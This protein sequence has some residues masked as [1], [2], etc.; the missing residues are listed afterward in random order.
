MSAVTFTCPHCGEPGISVTA[1]LMSS[2]A[3]WWGRSAT[4]R[5]CRQRSRISGAAVNVQFGIFVAALASIPWLL[6]GDARIAVGYLVA[7]A[8]LTVGLFAP[9]KKDLTS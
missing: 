7:A 1:K 9:M 3:L 6:D 2:A 5:L 8:I 4:C